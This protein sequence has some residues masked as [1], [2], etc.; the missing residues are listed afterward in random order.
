MAYGVDGV[1]F[2]FIFSIIFSLIQ[3]N[4]CSAEKLKVCILLLAIKYT[5]YYFNSLVTV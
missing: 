4:P 5:S 1:D 3:S 2:E